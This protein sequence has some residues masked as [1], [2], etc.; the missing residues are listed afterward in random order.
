MIETEKLLNDLIALPSVNPAFLP[1][2]DSKAGER[3]VAELL[4]H[5]ASRA[6]LESEYKKVLPQRPNL[7]VRLVPQG[8]AR[9]RILLAPHLDTVNAAADQFVPRRRNGRVYGRGACDTKG[10]VAAMFT[11]LCELA[12]GDQR[13]TATEIVFVGLVDEENSQNGSRAL[14]A[15]GYKADLAIVGEPTSAKVVTA[16]KGS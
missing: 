16:H 7:L 4:E 1:A 8:K 15:S 11:A 9:Q 5:R 6:G 2:G 12:M 13:P 10:S 14:A 3:A